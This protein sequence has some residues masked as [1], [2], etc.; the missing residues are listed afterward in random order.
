[1]RHQ[2]RVAPETEIARVEVTT[3]NVP[4]DIPG[5]IEIPFVPAEKRNA[6]TEAIEDTIVVVGQPRQ[7]KRKRVKATDANGEVTES[8]SSSQLSK[9]AKKKDPEGEQSEADI[10]PFDYASAPNLLDESPAVDTK[11]DSKAAKKG[12]LKKGTYL[13]TRI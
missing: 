12:K 1:M 5:Q 6:K 7:K 11:L 8:A 9:K 10:E 4:S 2:R 3:T 13:R